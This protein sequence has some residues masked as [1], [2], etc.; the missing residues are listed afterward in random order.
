MAEEKKIDNKTMGDKETKSV[1]N[2]M[3]TKTKLRLVN[4]RI[5]VEKQKMKN[6]DELEELFVSLNKNINKCVELLGRSIKGENIGKKLSAIEENNKVSF[7]KSIYNI[8]SD[9]EEVKNLLS[10]LNDERDEYQ[11]MIRRENQIELEH[12]LEKEKESEKEKEENK[13]EKE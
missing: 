9:R 12:E 7:N 4:D 13:E 1:D 6:L 2:K 11:E 10:R 3:D 8:N 5:D